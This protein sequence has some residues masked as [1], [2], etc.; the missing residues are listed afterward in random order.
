MPRRMPCSMLGSMPVRSA[1]EYAQ[2]NVTENVW[3]NVR[4]S[5][6]RNARQKGRVTFR[7]N[8]SGEC[9]RKCPGKCLGEFSGKCRT[10]CSE[11][12]SGEC[13]GTRSEVCPVPPPKI[14]VCVRAHPPGRTPAQK[15]SCCNKLGDHSP[16][17]RG[18]PRCRK[19]KVSLKKVATI[20][21]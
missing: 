13:S 19:L 8:G 10:K 4:G 17:I 21:T 16:F 18:E 3:K 12:C 2:E 11:P 20:R 15:I 5:V 6:R 9:S 14:T 1:Q 7:E